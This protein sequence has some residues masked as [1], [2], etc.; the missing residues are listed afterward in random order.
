MK[1][2]SW[3]RFHFN[4]D[5]ISTFAYAVNDTTALWEGSC[6]G[7]E[8]SSGEGISLLVLVFCNRFIDHIMPHDYFLFRVKIFLDLLQI[9]AVFGV[10][11]K[12]DSTIT[13]HVL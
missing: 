6:F 10:G 8:L 1:N 9:L 2:R 4:I 13:V 11:M 7:Q 3:E 5:V 12:T